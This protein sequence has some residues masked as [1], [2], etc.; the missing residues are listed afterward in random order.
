MDQSNN[1]VR[2]HI[3]NMA[4]YRAYQIGSNLTIRPVA[5]YGAG[6]RS[7][8]VVQNNNKIIELERSNNLISRR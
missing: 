2:R 4:D 6:L 8:K 5:F 3:L 1:L 7:D